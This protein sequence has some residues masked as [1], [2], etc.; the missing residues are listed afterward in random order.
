VTKVFR[1]LRLRTGETPVFQERTVPAGSRLAGWSLLCHALRIAA[2][3]RASACVSEQH[4]RGS[5]RLEGA[6]RVFDKRYWPGNT[7]ADHLSFAL[8][9][10]EINLLLLKRVFE[11][12]PRQE[13]EAFVRAT[14]TG[15]SPR[16][17]WYLYE[18]ITGRTLDLEDAP[19]A[20][21]A[22]LLDSEAYFTGKP[23]LSKRHRTATI[24]LARRASLR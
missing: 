18:A 15:V 16:R 3:V 17:A 1:P 24:C 6:W 22:D 2:P 10:E 8:R 7:F 21:A 19:N 11:A 12:V 14:P 5:S 13:V 4:V 23:R 9:H 20:P